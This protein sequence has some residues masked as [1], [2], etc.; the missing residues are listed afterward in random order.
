MKFLSDE[1]IENRQQ[2]LSD[3]LVITH[4]GVRVRGS[5]QH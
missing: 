1:I 4:R 5:G 2:D 3:F